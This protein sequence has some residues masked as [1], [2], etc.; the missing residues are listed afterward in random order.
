LLLQAPLANCA[1]VAEVQKMLRT[2]GYPIGNADGRWGAKS[3]DA[4]KQFQTNAGLNVTGKIDDV[5]A[6]ALQI[7]V[8]SVEDAA[9]KDI[10][11]T[12][13]IIPKTIVSTA[14]PLPPTPITSTDKPLSTQDSVITS[15]AGIK[16][17]RISGGCFTMGGGNFGTKE[18]CVHA[19]G[20]FFIGQYEITQGQWRAVNGDNPSI[21]ALGTDYPVENVSWNAVHKFIDKLNKHGQGR[22][23]LPTEA[24][25][26]Y[27][28][29]ANAK[30][31]YWW[32]DILPTCKS[33]YPNSANFNGKENCPNA[34]TKV[35]TYQPN[36][37]GLYDVHGNVWEWVEDVYLSDAYQRYQPNDPV[38]STGGTERVFRGGSW[39]YPAVAMT[40]FNRDHAAPD[41][42][43]SHLGFRLIYEP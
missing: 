37:F 36:T 26:E 42:Q 2:L 23:R 33:G 39:L 28:A 9:N 27:S 7:S 34:I 18:V 21:N 13:E 15:P 12:K 41:F 25:W 10:A 14:A 38:I 40:V 16:F 29:R 31:M 35:G 3:R 6:Q 11:N 19:N 24:E 32:G 30:T 22:Y 8:K 20:N 5:T 17:V 43:F 4:L 1:T